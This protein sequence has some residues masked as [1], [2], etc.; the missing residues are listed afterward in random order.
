MSKKIKIYIAIASLINGLI[1]LFITML[2]LNQPF[3]RSDEKALVKTMSLIKNFVIKKDSLLVKDFLFLNVSHDNELIEKQNDD[4]FPIG[5][6]TITDRK[7]IADLLNFLSQKQ[8]DFKFILCDIDFTGNSPYDTLLSYQLDKVR[9]KI[10]IPYHQNREHPK[11]QVNMGLA[12]Y[13]AVDDEFVKYRLLRKDIGNQTQKTIP[14]LMFEQLNKAEYSKGKWVD[15]YNNHAG[16]SNFIL[17]IRINNK[18]Y[19]S[20]PSE[21]LGI[22]I[23]TG[24]SDSLRLALIRNRIIVLGDFE[25]EKNDF[26]KT[27]TGELSGALILTNAYIAL[28]KGDNLIPITLFPM[29]F[30]WFIA[31][32]LFIFYPTNVFEKWTAFIKRKIKLA[33][34]NMYII[35]LVSYATLFYIIS[36]FCFFIYSI[37]INVL[38]LTV[39]VFGLEHIIKWANKKFKWGLKHKTEKIKK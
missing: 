20:S 29:L 25:N 27:L 8:N 38:Y 11:F 33:I 6:E 7:K 13:T 19:R 39:Y 3:V 4:S 2:M 31:I 12:D 30:L 36:I 17:N 22:F 35:G 10:I 16:F 26:H 18:D 21:Q 23:G 37:Q 34:F 14:L 9:N 15:R 24:Y 1:M 5:N 28:V 32:S